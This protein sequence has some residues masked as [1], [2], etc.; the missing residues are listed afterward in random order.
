VI[1]RSTE[2]YC[3]AQTLD[4]RAYHR[5]AE[6]LP[7]VGQRLG[8]FECQRLGVLALGLGQALG[9]QALSDKDMIWDRL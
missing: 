3:G 1:R 2:I 9:Q 5:L 6:P 7:Q 8:V 4:R